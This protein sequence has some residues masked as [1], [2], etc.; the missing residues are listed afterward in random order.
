MAV[1]MAE[2]EMEVGAVEKTVTRVTTMV[3][4]RVTTREE[5]VSRGDDA[6]DCGWQR[7][8]LMACPPLG[9]GIIKRR[10]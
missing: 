9:R 2:M 10:G 5:A 3:T 7:L 6:S 1:T 4:T 8:R